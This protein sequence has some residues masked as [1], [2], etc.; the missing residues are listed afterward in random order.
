[1]SKFGAL[2][3]YYLLT[4]AVEVSSLIHVDFPIVHE[5]EDGQHVR[6]P[7]PTM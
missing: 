2:V 1:M 4:F 7:D 6:E 3:T 5:V